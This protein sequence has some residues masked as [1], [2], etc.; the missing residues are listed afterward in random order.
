[1]GGASLHETG[2]RERE[3]GRDKIKILNFLL[4]KFDHKNNQIWCERWSV[5]FFFQKVRTAVSAGAID[6]RLY[7]VG[8]ECETKFSHEGTLYLNSVEYYD[9]IQNTWSNVAEMKYARSFAAVAV[10]NGKKGRVFVCL[11]K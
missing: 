11:F 9:P 1:M 7:A 5:N 4:S 3:R 8:G 10:L 6:G 2:K